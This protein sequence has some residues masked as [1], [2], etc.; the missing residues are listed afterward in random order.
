[1]IERFIEKLLFGARWLMAPLYLGLALVLALLGVRFFVEAWHMLGYLFSSSDAD[2]VLVTLSLLDLVMVAN[3]VV[4]VMLSGYE[5]FISHIEVAEGVDKPAWMGKLDAATIK[6]KLAISIVAIASIHLLKQ[7]MNIN[8]LANDKMVL[9]IVT[10][11]A[12]VIGALFLAY[13]DKIAFD[14][15][16][17][18]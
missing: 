10:Y 8:N 6:L 16:R 17:K 13:V 14:S 7:F 3:L 11:L 9:T 4:M 2:I 12:F 18:H 5:N 15:H 1:M